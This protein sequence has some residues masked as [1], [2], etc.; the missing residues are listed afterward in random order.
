MVQSGTFERKIVENH[1]SKK[2][3][4]QFYLVYD[5]GK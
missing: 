5:N 1:D 2:V 3:Q 4:Y